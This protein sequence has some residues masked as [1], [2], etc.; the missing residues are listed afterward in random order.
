M[1]YS[2]TATA[3]AETNGHI[4]IRDTHIHFGTAANSSQLANPAEVFL[5]A[6]A[7][8]ML[9]NVARFSEMM[10]FSYEKVS[11]AVV[12]TREEKPPRIEQLTYTLTI[13]SNDPRLNPKLLKKNIEKFGTIY[14]TV[15]KSCLIEGH[16]QVVE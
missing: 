2:V 14:N 16:I 3:A 8:C 5:S 12:A 1:K 7:A 4:D 6:F 13:Q 9:K 11:V 10:H 15:A